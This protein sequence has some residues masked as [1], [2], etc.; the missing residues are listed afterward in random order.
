MIIY[1]GFFVIINAIY[2]PFSE[3]RGLEQRFR[4]EYR[5]YKQNVPRWIPRIHPWKFNY[6]KK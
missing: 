1:F 5:I 2:I 4:E 6:Q 3:E